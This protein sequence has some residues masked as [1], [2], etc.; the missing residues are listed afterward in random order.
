[1]GSNT[2]RVVN[3]IAG[4]LA[5]IG[6]AALVRRFLESILT[7]REREEIAGRWELVKLLNRGVSQRHVAERLGMSLCKITRGSREL[8]KKDSAFKA[9]LERHERRHRSPEGGRE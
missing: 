2:T 3:E 5:A 4:E 7:P 9:V 1:M 8:K 6:D